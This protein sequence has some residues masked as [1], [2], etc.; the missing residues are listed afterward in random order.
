MNAH[1]GET[2]RETDPVAEI[3]PG[4]SPGVEVGHGTSPVAEIVPGASPGVEVGHETSPDTEIVPGTSVGVEVGHGTSPDTE[5]DRRR[6]VIEMTLGKINFIFA[7]GF[8]SLLHDF[9][10]I[11]TFLGTNISPPKN[12]IA[13]VS[14]RGSI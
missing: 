10:L 6:D 11:F 12:P 3:V 1:V 2:G 7:D 8:C 13:P 5:I 4:T 9:R 14:L